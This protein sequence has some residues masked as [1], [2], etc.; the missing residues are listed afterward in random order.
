MGR[1]DGKRLVITGAGSGL[2]HALA[3]RFA[4]AGWRVAVTDLDGERAQ[5]TLAAVSET[6][7]TGFARV[8]DVRSDGDV[9][10]LVR[11]TREAFGGVDVV[12]NNAGV[13][14]AG[15]VAETPI[16]DWHW[17]LDINLLGVVRGCR[18]FAPVL[19]AQGAG[20]IVN[21]ASFAGV[22]QAPAMA[23]YNVAKAGV[24]ALSETLR[25]ELARDGVGVSV[26]CPSF[27]RSNILEQFRSPSEHMRGIAGKLVQRSRHTASEVADAIYSGVHD[28]RF[29]I[30]P[31]H[32]ARWRWRLKRFAPE[33]YFRRLVTATRSFL[34]PR[35]AVGATAAAGKKDP[36]E[37]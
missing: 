8:C 30:I 24:I 22:A 29:M 19:S 3:L 4:S 34:E 9:D 37:G 14:A 10:E 23:S 36:S 11:H 7:A 16:N 26:A 5:A 35:D 25:A 27:F 17:M 12:V 31:Q 21:V 15:T 13:G 18:A 32:E 28:G 20:H 33:W 2:G 6:G 1:F